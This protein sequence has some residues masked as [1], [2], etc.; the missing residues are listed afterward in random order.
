VSKELIVQEART[1]LG[2]RWQHQACRKGV[3]TDCIG[4]VGGVAEELGLVGGA[5][6]RKDENLRGYGRTPLP[7]KLLD[8]CDRYLDRIAIADVDIG[9]VL[10]IAFPKSPQ[11]FAIVSSL[12]PLRIIHAYSQRGGVVETQA[13][14]PKSRI[15]R[16]YRFR[17]VTA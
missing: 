3:A 4:L 15:V 16:A 11:H 8:G 5:V 13:R 6:W 9:D 7:E 17:G 1:W 10:V 2:T 14:I 12:N